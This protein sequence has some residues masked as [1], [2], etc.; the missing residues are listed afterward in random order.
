MNCGYDFKN[1]KSTIL[2][3]AENEFTIFALAGAEAVVGNAS[4]GNEVNF[5]QESS[6]TGMNDQDLHE[7]P[8]GLSDEPNLD[9][10]GD[11]EL[12]LAEADDPD[13]ENWDI[14][15]TLTEDLSGP[16]RDVSADSKFDAEPDAGFEVLG[17]GF[18]MSTEFEPADTEVAATESDD[19]SVE[20]TSEV[21]SPPEMA[22]HDDQKEI[23]FELREDLSA[24]D[25]LEEG[26]APESLSQED[27]AQAASLELIDFPEQGAEPTAEVELGEISLETELEL[28]NKESETGQNFEVPVDLKYTEIDRSQTLE[29]E[30]LQL[31]LETDSLEVEPIQA[32]PSPAPGAAPED[33][34]LKMNSNQDESN[35]MPSDE[36]STQDR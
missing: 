32:D 29:V 14:G 33:L 20:A 21:P 3:R 17:L 16:G 24:Q 27:T 9:N 35:S 34:E 11:F 25:T 19:Y 23:E 8:T 28:E 10:A 31:D 4:T 26:T 13:L 6:D 5:H 12:D 2:P 18:D 30:G 36:E 1:Q 15:A 22:P 7:S